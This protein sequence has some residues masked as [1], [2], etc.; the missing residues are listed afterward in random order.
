MYQ[1]A[2]HLN[3]ILI[4]QYMF[5]IF[6]LVNANYSKEIIRKNRKSK[7]FIFPS[8]FTETRC[9]LINIIIKHNPAT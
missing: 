4:E 2:N 8:V 1:Y 3:Y 9:P 5:F 6:F 7:R